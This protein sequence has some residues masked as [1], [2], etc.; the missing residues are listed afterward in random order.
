MVPIIDVAEENIAPTELTEE[1]FQDLSISF[2][3]IG[4]YFQEVEFAPGKGRLVLSPE[5]QRMY[6]EDNEAGTQ[7]AEDTFPIGDAGLD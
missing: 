3:N 5:R 4:Q 1:L 2:P 7:W 6:P